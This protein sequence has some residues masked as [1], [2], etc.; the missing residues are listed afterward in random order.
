MRLRPSESAASSVCPP[1][2][3]APLVFSV[4]SQDLAEGWGEENLFSSLASTLYLLSGAFPC[5]NR[6]DFMLHSGVEGALFKGKFKYLI[7]DHSTEGAE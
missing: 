2:P 5:L 6:C 4:F 7:D 1:P 3:P